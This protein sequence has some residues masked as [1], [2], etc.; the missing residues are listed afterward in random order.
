MKSSSGIN[1]SNGNNC[2]ENRKTTTTSHPSSAISKRVTKTNTPVIKPT[3]AEQQQQLDDFIQPAQSFYTNSISSFQS[4]SVSS[5]FKFEITPETINHFHSTDQQRR[6]RIQWVKRHASFLS[7]SKISSTNSSIDFMT[8]TLKPEVANLSITAMTSKDF[9]EEYQTYPEQNEVDQTTLKCTSINLIS[10]DD[11]DDDEKGKMF[12][13]QSSQAV[14]IDEKPKKKIKSASHHKKIKSATK[15]PKP[16]SAT[17]VIPQMTISSLS[18]T[19]TASQAEL[20]PGTMT[21]LSMRAD[22]N[23]L[24]KNCITVDT[25]KARSNL[26]VVRLCLKDLGWREVMLIVLFSIDQLDNSSVHFLR[27]LIRISIGIRLLS[28]KEIPIFHSRLVE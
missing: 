12:I 5:K 18:P 2:R 27:H 7:K 19:R 24:N 1:T 28:M 9:A 10:D 16:P 13:D 25:N 14:M 4:E 6:P 23:N 17:Q 8:T 15:R 21:K 3:T 20:N 26:E 22:D 11:D